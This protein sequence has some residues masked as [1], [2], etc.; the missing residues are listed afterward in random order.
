[1]VKRRKVERSPPLK[2]RYFN[3]AGKKER[4]ALIVVADEP[5]EHLA[6]D[7]SLDEGG[8]SGNSMVNGDGREE[9]TERAQDVPRYPYAH[10]V[11]VIYPVSRVHLTKVR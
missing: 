4:S 1:M 5:A 7:S 6:T 2:A 3:E 8:P 10:V 11:W 9:Q